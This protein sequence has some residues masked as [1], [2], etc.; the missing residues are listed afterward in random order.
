MSQLL[1]ILMFQICNRQNLH[2][3]SGRPVDQSIK[4]MLTFSKMSFKFVTK[5]KLIRNNKN[6]KLFQ[7]K[8]KKNANNWHAH[9]DFGCKIP[10]QD[11]G[12][13]MDIIVVE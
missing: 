7:T 1:L 9:G 10:V 2:W 5:K 6:F 3:F 12:H 4:I 11:N 13:V 8:R